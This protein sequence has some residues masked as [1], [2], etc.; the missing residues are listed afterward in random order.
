[1]QEEN[2]DYVR[3]A[4]ISR[5]WGNKGEVVADNLEGGLRYFEPGN[6]LK[7]FPPDG[8]AL[9]L[10]LAKAREHKGRVILSF[11]DIATISDAERLRGAEVRCEK[12]DLETLPDGR[13]YLNDL[14]GC[15]MMD[16][17]TGRELGTVGEV[18]EPPGGVL[19][20][21][22]LRENGT[23]MMVP[24]ATEICR[25]VDLNAKR[26]KVRLPKGIEEL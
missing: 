17:E 7:V 6:R 2:A 9:E 1:M 10:E 23:E 15:N 11:A 21:S 13:Y 22:V 16:A 24:F 18:Y 14:V 3:L 25:E 5:P 19:L 26:I 20:F 4:R 8:S 12:C